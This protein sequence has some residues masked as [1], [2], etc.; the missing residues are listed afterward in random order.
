[1]T[2][3]TANL[4]EFALRLVTAVPDVCTS[5][6]RCRWPATPQSPAGCFATD[7]L[8][9]E[10]VCLSADG[11]AMRGDV[12]V[13]VLPAVSRPSFRPRPERLPLAG[14]SGLH[15][16]CRN[17]DRRHHSVAGRQRPNC[18]ASGARPHNRYGQFS[19]TAK[20]FVI[21]TAIAVSDLSCEPGL[22]GAAL[23]EGDNRAAMCLGVYG[24]D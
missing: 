19:P 23:A 16:A 22:S 7:G 20:S 15:A 8:L 13:R 6:R 17:V 5:S 1:M 10:A 2:D 4:N 14:D 3:R 18:F 11:P 24:A 9:N 21:V 12:T